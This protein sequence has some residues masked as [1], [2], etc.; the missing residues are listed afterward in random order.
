[1]HPSF[2]IVFIVSVL[3]ASICCQETPIPASQLP[4]RDYNPH[5]YI[6]PGLRSYLESNVVNGFDNNIRTFGIQPKLLKQFQKFEQ[7]LLT[8][9]AIKQSLVVPYDQISAARRTAKFVRIA[10]NANHNAAVLQSLAQHAQ[11]VLS[12]QFQSGSKSSEDFNDNQLN[13]V[14]Q[15]FEDYQGEEE[16]IPA[17]TNNDPK[18]Y[19]FSYAVKD[20]K[21]GDDFS[22]TQRRQDGAVLGNYQVQLPDGRMQIV[23][24]TADDVNGYRADVRYESKIPF[25]QQRQKENYL[26]QREG[27][28]PNHFQNSVTQASAPTY[29]Q[30]PQQYYRHTPTR[31]YDPNYNYYPSSTEAPDYY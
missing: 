26:Y 8:N 9:I 30:S 25:P 28:D 5:P 4:P 27:K 12:N 1:M 11:K 16:I 19:R 10:A 29:L 6:V 17:A 13:Q 14:D 7:N 22:H 31:Q 24:Y 3:I 21:S 23:K 20:H 18:R 15:D 2:V